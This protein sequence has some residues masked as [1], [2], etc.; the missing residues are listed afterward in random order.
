MLGWNP[1]S[2]Q[3]RGG[4][5]EGV[6]SRGGEVTSELYTYNCPLSLKPQTILSWMA[7]CVRKFELSGLMGASP[8][9]GVFWTKITK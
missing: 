5:S 6:V 7:L 2:I 9:E 1:A 4:R 8:F 3:S